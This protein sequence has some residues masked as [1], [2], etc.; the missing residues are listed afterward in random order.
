MKKVLSVVMLISM[1]VSSLGI[2]VSARD[3]DVTQKFRVDDSFALG[4]VNEDGTVDAKDA[5]Y[6]TANVK[7]LEGYD[8]NPEA[9]DFT[10]EGEFD[11]KD[12]YYIK[13]CLSGAASPADYGDELSLY[14]LTI[15]G[16]D[17]SE[18]SFVVPEGERE[19]SNI[20][21]AYRAFYKYIAKATG[22]ELPLSY[23]TSSTEYGIYFNNI[24]LNSEYGQQLGVEGYKYEVVDGNL[25]I[26]GTYRG[27]MYAVY[28][29]LEEYLGYRFYS[30][31]ETFM[32]KT[33]FAD[34]PEG[35]FEEHVPKIV[36]RF[37]GQTFTN[38]HEP[39][40][41]LARK[42]NG[43]QI[44]RNG[45]MFF[46][47]Q[48]GPQFINAHSFGYY[49]S[50][51]TGIMPPDD[52]TKTLS[53]RYQ[54]KHDSGFVQN[55]LAWNPCASLLDNEE[56]DYQVLFTGFRETIDMLVNAWGREFY[57]EEG[58]SSMSFSICDNQNY[59]TCRFCTQ[60]ALGNEK[61]GVPAEGYS[62]LYI[63]MVN[64]AAVDIQQYYPG[65][66]VYTIL[67][68]Y[69]IPETVRPNEHLII[70]Y[71]GAGCD[72][73]I[74]NV[75]ECYPDG[76]Q[77]DP[78]GDGKGLYN[79]NNRLA[80]LAWG[81]FC[82]ESGAEMWYWIYPVTYHYYLCCSPMIP[83]YYYNMKFLVE[84]CNVTGFYYEG[85][86]RTYSFESLKAYI[87]SKMMWEPDMSYEQ[88]NE[89]IKE[90]LYLYYG[91]GYEELFEYIQMQTE[92]GDQCGTCWVNNFD[93]P[94]DMYSYEYLAENY[95]YMRALLTT[96]LEKAKN[97]EQARRVETLIM[98]CDFM[99]LSA[100]Y[101]DMYTNGDEES[102]KVYE[103]RYTWMYDYIDANDFDIFSSDIYVL[104][105]VCDFSINP[106]TQFYEEGSRRPGVTP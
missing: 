88:Y 72:N 56:S 33:R 89:Y 84:E 15:A 64:R 23:V 44:Y 63:N 55:E 92:A 90:Y 21:F 82:K 100:S 48:T 58:I 104:P 28:E 101:D 10:A 47:T 78:D 52:G 49:W 32:Y 41:Y 65:M 80:L 59:H 25:N 12:L 51:A 34:I 95:E 67:Y 57:L 73:H 27:N 93:R 79:T 31:D 46:G 53:Q 9:S 30:C 14:K 17:L 19:D 61:K 91:D 102:R 8:M 24:E 94:G 75:E 26:Y 22:V 11:A 42:M 39:G 106:M 71:C 18:Y 74:L 76:G 60:T 45:D 20:W 105:E 29:I 37:C 85:G 99:G 2:L 103:E 4:D 13:L 96:A 35:A 77:L 50:M 36:F 40:Y 98:C 5:L 81:Q 97:P 1:L 7:G 62:G 86:G 43:T 54:E 69:D 38:G 70:M 87:C 83:N 68:N 16:N 66:K 6:M 3:V